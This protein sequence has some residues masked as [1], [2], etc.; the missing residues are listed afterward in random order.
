MK[1]F[2]TLLEKLKEINELSAL[3]N[4][5]Y[6]KIALLW[7]RLYLFEY[8]QNDL[9]LQR[10]MVCNDV[11]DFWML[12]DK[13]K[14]IPLYPKGKK[15]QLQVIEEMPHTTSFSTQKEQIEFDMKQAIRV[16]TEN[17][18]QLGKNYRTSSLYHSCRQCSL[19]I[20]RYLW[21]LGYFAR[22]VS[23]QDC[24]SPKV[25]HIFV[26]V[27]ADGITPYIVDITYTQ[28]CTIAVCMK[29]ARFQYEDG[30]IGPGYF[31]DTKEKEE[32]MDTFLTNGF[33]P[34]TSDALKIYGDSFALAQQ[35]VNSGQRLNLTF[36]KTKR[37]EY[38]DKVL[39]AEMIRK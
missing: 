11:N 9:L 32:I 4:P 10:G 2:R 23:V 15:H 12:D 18:K 26:V 36:P 17:L 38:L 37:N 39:N 16:A 8:Q 25:F 3:P 24:F 6:E 28:F 21:N 20:S 27:E 35:S 14:D 5:P 31:I 7:K 33:F 13:A 29:E 22:C 34:C 1:A 19:I 30:W